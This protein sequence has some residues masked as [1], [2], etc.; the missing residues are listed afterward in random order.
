MKDELPRHSKDNECGIVNLQNSDELG[1]HWV[2]YFKTK[3]EKYY[4][5]SYGN[6]KPPI[7]LV[8]YLGRSN[9]YYNSEPIQQF[10]DPPICGHLCLLLLQALSNGESFNVSTL[11]KLRERVIK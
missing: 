4:F 1:S 3:K 5:D 11:K 7:E 8:K 9:L 10:N 2:A 6:A